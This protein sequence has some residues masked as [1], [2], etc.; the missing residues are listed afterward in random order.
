MKKIYIKTTEACQLK[1]R[2]CYIGDNRAKKA[3]FDEKKVIAWIKSNVKDEELQITFHGGEP[4]LC[5]LSKMQAICDAFPYAYIDATTNLIYEP[6]KMKDIIGFIKKSFRSRKSKTPFIKT[7]WDYRIRFSDEQETLFWNNIGMIQSAGIDILVITCLTEPLIKGITAETFYQYMKSHHVHSIN[8]E[9]L[10]ENTT[11][12]KSLIPKY[13][14]IDNWLL[15]LYQTWKSDEEK[16]YI[17]FFENIRAAVHGDYVDCRKRC[18]MQEVRTINA[19]GTI[20]GCPNTAVK[21]F[22]ADTEGHYNK[23]LH[24]KL[25][26]KECRP[27]MECLACELYKVCHGDCHQLSWQ[28]N[29]C[30]EP[31]KLVKEIIHDETT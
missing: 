15:R 13:E 27:H 5:P 16:I 6:G 30:P 9:R 22:F 7:S 21:N 24:F 3:F 11:A 12:D 8:F 19:D 14:D 29:V 17:D 26:Q 31:K 20:G 25:I 4:F 1:C 2:H 10:T 28:E 23:E 18:C